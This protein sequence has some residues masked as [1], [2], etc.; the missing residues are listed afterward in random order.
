MNLVSIFL[1]FST[2]AC[3][4]DSVTNYKCVDWM[5]QCQI[6]NYKITNDKDATFE[7]C[8][9]LIPDNLLQFSTVP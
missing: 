1:Y 3:T 4:E 8:T 9:E 5:M 7:Y 6:E 2:L